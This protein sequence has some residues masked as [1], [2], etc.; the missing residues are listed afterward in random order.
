MNIAVNDE[1]HHLIFRTS[2]V[3]DA[4]AVSVRSGPQALSL[5]RC[6]G[7]GAAAAGNLLA[8]SAA[9]GSQLRCI[10]LSH[11]DRLDL[12]RDSPLLEIQEWNLS[13]I[14]KTN[15]IVLDSERYCIGSGIRIL[16]LHNCG[17]LGPHELAAV[18][19]IS[20]AQNILFLLSFHFLLFDILLHSAGCHMSNA[21]VFNDWRLI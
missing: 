21:G 9:E 6:F 15:S 4:L 16:A 17:N 20:D 12:P 3:A 2:V 1:W 13:D 10:L 7:L 18:V 8:A 14:A 19:S 11:L 5:Q